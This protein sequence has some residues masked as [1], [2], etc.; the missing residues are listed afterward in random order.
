ML[1]ATPAAVAAPRPQPLQGQ[2]EKLDKDGGEVRGVGFKPAPVRQFDAPAPVWPKAG[3]ASIDLPAKAATAA[4]ADRAAVRRAGGLPVSVGRAP[5]AAGD[6]LSAV[7]VDLLDRAAVPDRWRDGLVT[8]LAA[9]AGKS[10]GRAVVRMDYS[11][12][13]HAYGAEWASRLRLWSLPECA[14]S[15][16]EQPR[17][18]AAALPS[19]HDASGAVVS[20]EVQVAARTLVALAAAPSG[21]DGD[22]SATDLAPSSSWTA[23]DSSGAFTWSYPMDAPQVAGGLTPK[24][25]LSYSSSSVDGRSSATNNQPGWIGEGFD[26]WPGFIERRYVPCTMDKAD[27][28]NN[29]AQTGDLCWRSH[30]AV[31]S[32]NGSSSELVY[33]S[34][35]GWHSRSEDGSKIER[36]TG[37]DNGDNDGEHWRVTTTDGTQYYFGRDDL[38]GQSAATNS[39]WT[40]PVYGNHSGEPCHASAF[41][42]SDC[43]QA[44]RW[45]LDY[46]VDPRGNTMSYWYTRETNQ[47]AAEVTDS[48]NVSYVRGGALARIDYGTWDRGSADRSVSA[49]GQVVFTAADRC[50]S[51]CSEHTGSRWPDVPWDQ[52]CKSDATTCNDYTP[53][54]WST[55]RLAK[56]TS[57]VWDTTK[58]TPAWQDVESWTLT[59]SFP[60]PGDGQ[61]AG[62]WLASIVHTGL[63]GTAIAEPPV[64]FDPVAMPNRVLT[65]TNTTNNWQRLAAIRTETGALIQITYSL[66]QCTATDLPESPHNNTRLCYPVKGPDPYDSDLDITE[67]W[68]KYV[69]RQV[70][71]TDVQ[72]ADG[73]QAPTKNTYYTYVGSPAWHYA[74]DDGLSKPKYKTWSQYR[75]YGTVEVQ[76]GDTDKT[77]TRTTYLRGMHGDKLAPSGGTRSVTVPASLGSETVYDE[78][79]FAGMKREQVVYNGTADKPVSRTVFVPWRSTPTASRTIN[80]DT[81]TARFAGTKASYQATALGVDGARG[82][83]T[84]SS[85]STFDDTYGTL[86]STQDNGDTAVSGDEKC[87]TT[88]YNRNTA[89]HI[90]NMPRR[91]T[92]TALPCGTAPTSPDHLVSDSVTFYDGASDAATAPVYGDATRVDGLKDWTA[93]G[94][95]VWQTI[96][97]TVHDAFGRETSKTDLKG[98]TTTVA[99]S[100]GAG[101]ITKVTS[102]S[103][104]GWVTTTEQSPYWGTPTKVTDP[105]GKITETTYDALGRNLAVWGPGWSRATYPEKPQERYSYVYSAN[106]SAYPYTKTE[107]LSANGNYLTTYEILDGFLRPRQTQAAAVGGGRVVTDTRYDAHGRTELVYGAHAEPGEPSGTLWWEPEWS[108]PSQTR[109][110]YDRANRVT[111]SVFLSGDGVTNIV[112][113]WRT[114]T[115][116]E[117][118]RTITVPPAGGT[119]TTRV[120]DVH[121]RTVELREHT[122]A[123]GASGAYQATKYTYDHRDKL[124]TM[125]DTA[126]NQWAR[127]YDVKGRE[128]ESRDP[129]KGLTTSKYNEFNELTETTDNRG[130]TLLYSYDALGRRTAISQAGTTPTKLVEWIHDK[131]YTGVT[132]RGQVTQKIRYVG[133]DAYKWQARGFNDRYLPTGVNY[134]I[135]ASEEKLAGTYVF[136]YGYSP[137]T[138]APTSISFPAGGGLADEQVTIGY[139]DVSGLPKTLGSAWSSVVSYVTGQQY[140]SYGE[141]TVTTLKTAGGVY[142]EQATSYDV[143]T[144]RV[145]TVTV[146]PETASG[147]VSQRKYAHDAIGNIIGIADT[148]VVGT[149]DY[150]CFQHDRLR[151]LAGAWTPA[152]AVDCKTAT[153]SAATVGGPAPYWLDWTID[154]VGNRTREVSHTAA[155]DTVRSYTVPASGAGV[156]RPH[157]VTSM[158]TTAPGASTGTTVSYG[159]DV[160]GNMTSRPGSGAAQ[161]LQWDAEGRLSS[162]TENGTLRQ[163]NVYDVDGTRLIRRDA[164][165][166]S[167]YLPGMEVR[168]TGTGTSATM[169]ATR[170]YTFAGKTVASR[171]SAGTLSW[172]FSDHHGT[173]QVSVDAATQRVGIRRQ[174]PYGG[175]RGTSPAWPN[176][177]GF[178]GGDLD[179]TGLVHIG[180]R[181][182]D[183]VLGRFISVDPEQN[184]ADPQQWNAYS[185]ANNSPASM[186]DPDGRRPLLVGD[187]DREERRILESYGQRSVQ[188][189]GKWVVEDIPASTSKTSRVTAPKGSWMEHYGK[190]VT[191][192]PKSGGYSPIYGYGLTDDTIFGSAAVYDEQGRL[193]AS[194]DNFRSGGGMLPGETGQ[195]HQ[196][197]E[198]RVVQ[199]FG[200]KGML[201]PGYTVRIILNEEGRSPCPSCRPMLEKTVE[202]TGIR[203]WVE[204]PGVQMEVYGD[205]NSSAHLQGT[206]IQPRAPMKPKQ[207]PLFEMPSSR[208]AKPPSGGGRSNTPRGGGA[209]GKIAGGVGV[210]GFGAD[211]YFLW[212]Y[213]PCGIAPIPTPACTEPAPMA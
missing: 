145:D 9:P 13:K 192:I 157:A 117:G 160:A 185:Y 34:G 31:L 135:P 41:T 176:Q 24:V 88:T 108:V 172:L 71:E 170:Y 168:R 107:S 11:A 128:I 106:R 64:T 210:I 5:G 151:R 166:A 180:A 81:V 8:R 103:P 202:R 189:D 161:T 47:Y 7:S 104:L 159:Y 102:T 54:F 116:D 27:S 50:L 32:L 33:E 65:Q 80:G 85:Q 115:I 51:D 197:V 94:G 163:A 74:D 12:F 171:T 118:D 198:P 169:S 73:H 19:S 152:T 155:G 100:T 21:S 42:D 164:T 206:S 55:K 200:D 188:R 35:K 98:N 110:L 178:V 158:T 132:V 3:S 173:Q 48:K 150:Q 6:R 203:V 133:T 87:V 16:P 20:A 56:V 184:L 67:W 68:H 136:G 211:L 37:G 62:L 1:T 22:Y 70:T 49:T 209:G 149:A 30:N 97:K 18:A 99:Y 86:V 40:A 90:V 4:R 186:S 52:E 182:Y 193:V 208:T 134:V 83:Q 60:S 127:K 14:L 53:T 29:P 109:T 59:H 111:N 141:P 142:T 140:S 146:K 119:V 195:I 194:D 121:G 175:T 112:E 167:L 75:G 174:T 84:T 46:V 113:R 138:G 137:Y 61:K 44:W 23:G 156:V 126:G 191:K 89:K 15:T 204:A 139:D 36:L 199:W 101:P 96:S 79:Q 196:H 38:P 124:V 72:L 26:F 148:P 95:T 43:T 165:G 2:V 205:K 77:L 17:C 25:G 181:E 144:R 212:R 82:W 190:T 69:V 131:L 66:P 207:A 120:E 162:V 58:T 129:D 57:R 122:T 45:N 63:A 105:N 76:V 93:G 213:G 177:K 153:P 125:T 78:D 179:P 143:Y 183:G 28:P 147:S 154:S 10:G 114:T 123:A 201:K 39:A 91:I 187:N 92:T 130:Q